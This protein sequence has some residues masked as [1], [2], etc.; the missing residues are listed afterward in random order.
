M[1]SPHKFMEAAE[2]TGLIVLID[3]WVSW[4]ACR[5]ICQWQCRYPF[6]KPLSVTVNISGLHVTSMHLVPEIK[7]RIRDTGIEPS[8]L[9]LEVSETIVMANPEVTCSALAQ[10][11]RLAVGTTIDGFGT[12]RVR[13]M[14]LRRFPVDTLKID[15]SL[16]NQL[17]SDRVSQ[18][19]VELILTLAVKL[20]QKLLRRASKR[21][22]RSSG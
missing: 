3:K 7:A 20:N 15:Q 17:L 21:P 12:G 9:Q 2:E 8:R 14:G 5:Q 13:L 1:I 6:V 16:I 4:Q 11:S 18:D 22:A 10:L 19:A